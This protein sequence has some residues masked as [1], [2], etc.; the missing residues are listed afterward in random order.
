LSPPPELSIL[1]PVKNGSKFLE[2]TL[3]SVLLQK[4][5][6]SFEALI[7]N[8]HSTDNTGEI[9]QKFSRK[10]A[11]FRYVES[12]EHGVGAA[13]K[14]GLELVKTKYVARIDS[15]DLMLPGR[16][17]A[18]LDFLEANPN[19]GIVGSQIVP[20]SD[21]PDVRLNHYFAS[22]FEIR[23]FMPLGN[24]F[25]DPSVM[26]RNSFLPIIGNFS[27]RLDGAEQYDYWMRLC[28]VSQV[29][30]LDVPLTEYRLHAEQFTQSKKVR[31]LITTLC[32]QGLWLT[33]FRQRQIKRRLRL[34]KNNILVR[35]FSYWR[36]LTGF[37]LT[38]KFLVRAYI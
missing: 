4:T 2:A 37:L 29:A 14:F 6:F 10:F 19:I 21:N 20:L 26:F 27:T 30:N 32:V 18:Q 7:V 34:S 15:D 25:A 36:L 13:L 8:D 28:Y 3:E 24:P 12:T 22:D 31:V 23:K 38:L 11:H 17:Q 1:I 33:G 16:L 9:A 35:P 5:E